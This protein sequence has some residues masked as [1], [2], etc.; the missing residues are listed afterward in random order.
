MRPQVT[1]WINHGVIKV[2]I[3]TLDLKWIAL[4]IAKQSENSFAVRTR[5]RLMPSANVALKS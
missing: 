4:Q 3:F 1:W 5:L 2:L